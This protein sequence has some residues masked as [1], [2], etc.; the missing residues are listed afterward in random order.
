[1]D[2][3]VGLISKASSTRGTN[4]DDVTDRL[5]SRYTVVLL[6]TFAVLVSLNQYVRNPITCWAPNHFTGAHTRFSTSY[7]WVRNTY[8][9]P[10]DV[11][12]SP[13]ARTDQQDGRRQVP[14]YQWIP[15]I[16]LGQAVLFYLPTLVWRA[17]NSKAGVDADSILG[18]AHKLAK[19]SQ[20]EA[21]ERTLQLL[22]K[23]FERFLGSRQDL[24]TGCSPG[25]RCLL[26]ALLCRVCGRRG[27]SYVVVL[28]LFSKLC[29][30]ANVVG[31]LFILNSVLAMTYNTFGIDLLKN[32]AEARDTGFDWTEDQSYVAF[33]RVTL[34]DI[35]VRG[36]DMGNTQQYTL[37]CVLPI[38]AYNEK[39]YAFLWFWMVFVA[40]ASCLS[41]LLWIIRAVASKDKTKFIANHL[42]M[43]GRLAAKPGLKDSELVRKFVS[44]YLRPDGSFLL[45]LVAHNTDNI[46]TTELISCM[47]DGWKLSYVAP[48]P[49]APPAH[50]GN[51][52]LY[53]DTSDLKNFE[54]KALQSA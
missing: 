1:M 17:L 24:R 23:H 25:L 3:L 11:Q 46:T 21:R 22:T 52:G 14:Y 7:C 16:L 32:L 15:F 27:G 47:W 18:A 20:P 5:S 13:T 37:Q 49:S 44:D 31:Q 45:R 2:K 54:M 28:F 34:C 26:S 42:K 12:I 51:G 41:L 50:V 4:Y 33:P 30:I 39:I 19:S 10:W 43:S 36:Q 40:A 9:L 48:A 8:Y 35:K 53:P 29:Y 38:N 6:V